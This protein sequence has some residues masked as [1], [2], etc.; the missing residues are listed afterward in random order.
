MP[1]PAAK[2]LEVKTGPNDTV[3]NCTG[4]AYFD[5]DA[6]VLVYLKNVTVK[7]PRYDMTGANELKI[8]F[9]KKPPRKKRSDPKPRN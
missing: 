1:P 6:G 8:F 4:G 5:A 7:D 9:E 2:P 3:I